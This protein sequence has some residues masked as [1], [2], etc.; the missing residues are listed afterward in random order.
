MVAAVLLAVMLGFIVIVPMLPGYDPYKQDLAGGLVPVWEAAPDGQFFVLGSDTLGRDMLD[1]LALAGRISALIAAGA[2][3]FSL[4]VGVLL[5]LVAGYFRGATEAVIMGFA[6]LQLSIPRILL[7]VAVTAMLGP[8]MYKLALLLGATSWVAYG[9]VARAMA[10]SLRTR[11]F[12]LAAT[13]Q[14]AGAAWNI[15]RHLLPN[16]LPQMLIV[17]SYEF[18]QIIIMESS[19]SYL[20]LG[21]LPPL[22]SWGM[23]VADGQNY[24][25][26]APSLAILPSIALFLLIAGLQILSQ[27]FTAESQGPALAGSAR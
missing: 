7:L 2:V 20:G 13:T 25:A 1:R 15:R 27:A 8:G 10:L 16:V 26:L 17:G 6:D 4:V 24:L 23:M 21:V 18:G 5:G 12:V 14:G 22:P 9:R 11:E 19:L 3:A